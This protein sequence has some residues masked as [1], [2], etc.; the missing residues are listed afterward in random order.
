MA[1]MKTDKR[2]NGNIRVK[3]ELWA[4]YTFCALTLCAAERSE[5]SLGNPLLSE[6]QVRNLIFYELN[7]SIS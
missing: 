5:G 6:C 4:G 3:K 7:Q 2:K 1:R